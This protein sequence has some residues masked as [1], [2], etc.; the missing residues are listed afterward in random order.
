MSYQL[1][2]NHKLLKFTRGEQSGILV[3]SQDL[4]VRLEETVLTICRVTAK[5]D[6]PL[7][8]TYRVVEVDTGEY[9][10]LSCSVG[11]GIHN[12]IL[13]PEEV[14]KIR[15]NANRPT[16]AGI[17]LALANNQFWKAD[18]K[19]P[20]LHC[21]EPR[22][23]ASALPDA[24]FQ[25]T[26]KQI[27]GHKNNARAFI[28]PPYN[29]ECLILLPKDTPCETTLRLLH[30]GDWLSSQRGWGK[31]FT[32]MAQI[33]DSFEVL[34][35]ICLPKS[36]ADKPEGAVWQQQA[37][38]LD[39]STPFKLQEQHKQQESPALPKALKSAEHSEYYHLPYVYQECPDEDIYNIAP[40]QHPL[41]RWSLYIIGLGLLGIAVHFMVGE[42]T[43]DAG[44][45]TRKAMDA[46]AKDD[47][48]QLKNL[49]KEPHSSDSITRAL[50]KL[51]AHLS[52]SPTSE[53]GEENER[54]RDIIFI[55]KH[56]DTDTTGHAD[57]IT[58]LRECALVLKL[59]PDTLSKLYMTEATRS[60]SVQDW[61]SKLNTAEME[62]WHKLLQEEPSMRHVLQDATLYPYA[63]KILQSEYVQGAATDTK[64]KEER[65]TDKAEQIQSV[66]CV[67]GEPLPDFFAQALEH[68]PFIIQ[69]GKWSI[70]RR[71]PGTMNRSRFAGELNE[72]GHFL[73]VE[74]ASG[75]VYRIVPGLSDIGIPTLSFKVQDG[76][77]QEL[78]SE[79]GNP[80]AAC[81][82]LQKDDDTYAS[83]MLLP[84]K[85]LKLQP[86]Q[87][88]TPPPAEHLDM[89]LREQDIILQDNS[90]Q[91]NIAAHK[92]Y[93][94]TRMMSELTLPK[95]QM[96]LHLPILTG[97]NKLENATQG[98]NSAYEWSYS[99][100]ATSNTSTDLFDCH[101]LR[102][103]D[104]SSSLKRTFHEQANTYCMG[105]KTG[106]DNFYS[107]ASLYA[108]SIKA[109][110]A[111]K[112]PQAAIELQRLSANNEFAEVMK[113][114]F[115][116]EPTLQAATNPLSQKEAE[117]FLSDTNTRHFMRKCILTTL[118]AGVKQAY[119]LC[120][121]EEINKSSP[122]PPVIALCL[123][124][125]SINTQGELVWKF[126]LREESDKQ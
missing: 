87:A 122:I 57:N 100:L 42:K 1:I 77:L 21:E 44:V 8:Y 76:K 49:T 52:A 13:T 104:F 22:L 65:N 25:A 31:T 80:A 78:Q 83:V 89:E 69:R 37:P 73:R 17:I 125:V 5:V 68:T 7:K 105:R 91:M 109:E 111:E 35:R 110:Q 108:I 20:S 115:H 103:Y 63:K 9:H 66:T 79:G 94:W 99:K 50:D 14:T 114:V 116:S 86:K 3:K 39:L 45:V 81:I 32:T 74:R 75:N 43:D 82:P 92:G 33:G 123:Q 97:A 95:D 2:Y 51:Y 59:E 54:M 120:R 47:I 90:G 84:R 85:E 28:T 10:I 102:V 4:P 71:F 11:S 19:Q 96:V 88:S 29:R 46:M 34:A 62:Q 15:S 67:E 113:D 119:T 101:L 93:P 30:E 64:Q 18:T 107:L 27:S 53:Q 56:A 58:K 40:S 118:S 124:Q 23:A 106:T 26:W 60:C 36:A 12:L 72:N 112:L 117:K 16:P 48:L 61:E 24:D 70:I 98:D 6:S 41:L 126:H 55:L 38:V 121:A